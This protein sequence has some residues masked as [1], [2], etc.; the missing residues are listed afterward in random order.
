LVHEQVAVRREDG[1]VSLGEVKKE[2]RS[3]GNGVAQY[4]AP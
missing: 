2:N 3:F 4:A 1:F